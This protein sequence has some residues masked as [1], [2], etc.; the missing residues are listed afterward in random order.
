MKNLDLIFFK[1]GECGG[2]ENHLIKTKCRQDYA[3]FKILGHDTNDNGEEVVL[4][5]LSYPV[6]CSC[7][8]KDLFV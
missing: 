1:D 2:M 5:T 8:Y 7:V 4:D 3:E 6:G